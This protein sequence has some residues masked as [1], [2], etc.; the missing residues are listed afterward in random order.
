MGLKIVIVI[1]VVL[2]GLFV[3]SVIIGARNTNTTGSADL[4]STTNSVQARFGTLMARQLETQTDSTGKTVWPEVRET[5]PCLVTPAGCPIPPNQT[6]TLLITKSEDTIRRV[7][8]A[9]F[10]VLKQGSIAGSAVDFEFKPVSDDPSAG[11]VHGKAGLTPTPA[12]AATPEVGRVQVNV[13][14]DGGQVIVTC[15]S[16]GGGCLVKLV[17]Q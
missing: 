7:R 12:P 1:G 13:S 11:E 17:A 6:R 14:P 3:A 8:R 2:V 16:G 5:P 15:R 9:T 4:T 10:A